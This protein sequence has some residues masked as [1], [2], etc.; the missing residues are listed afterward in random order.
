[1]RIGT[2]LLSRIESREPETH[3]RAGNGA[4]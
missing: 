2:V 1:V 4:R 3:Q